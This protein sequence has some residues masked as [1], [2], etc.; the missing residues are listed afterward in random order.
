MNVGSAELTIHDALADVEGSAFTGGTQHGV[1]RPATVSAA[2]GTVLEVGLVTW[3]SG[4]RDIRTFA[5]YGGPAAYE[6]LVKGVRMGIHPLASGL[7][8]CELS[9]LKHHVDRQPTAVKASWADFDVVLGADAKALLLES[10]ALEVGT[11]ADV[12]GQVG[13]RSDY[14]VMT[15][16]ETLVEPVFVAYVLARVLPIH[17]EFGRMAPIPVGLA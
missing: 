14:L 13:R 16:A 2:D 15:F 5:H 9:I 4:A 11:K 1:A 12:L 17:R 8:S 6:R 3:A 10:G 7:M